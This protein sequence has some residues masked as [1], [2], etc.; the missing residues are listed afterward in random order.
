MSPSGYR[1]DIVEYSRVQPAGS[2]AAAAADG[3]FAVNES[4]QNER[5]DSTPRFLK[6][7]PWPP[8]GGIQTNS[9]YPSLLCRNN[10]PNNTPAGA[11]GAMWASYTD[12]DGIR[13][14]ADC[15]L[16]PDPTWTASVTTSGNPYLLTGSTSTPTGNSNVPG[17]NADRPIVLNRPFRSVA[18]LGYVFRD[19]PF[20]T[21]DFFSATSAD[22]GLLD[23]FCLNETDSIL[24]AGAISANTRQPV[25]LKSLLAGAVKREQVDSP[26]QIST[27]EAETIAGS[28]ATRTTATPLANKADLP[29]AIQSLA[30]TAGLG[31]GKASLES[32][33]RSL[34]DVI[35]TRT[36]GIFAQIIAQ[37]GRWVNGRFIVEAEKHVWVSTAID[38]PLGKIID[39]NIEYVTNP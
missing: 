30:N 19:Q 7:L 6:N 9:F 24:R 1:N 11:N 31:Y 4:I 16:Y 32:V 12:P 3:G 5:F 22:G 15:G 37:S 35:Q 27:S 34:G 21:L 14:I 8:N 2:R 38:R 10:R 20:K 33:A 18:E 23:L 25:V 39:Q 17:N 36:W 26:P 13:R 29:S 28:L